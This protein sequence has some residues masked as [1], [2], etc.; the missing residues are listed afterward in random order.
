MTVAPYNPDDYPPTPLEAALL[1][2]DLGWRVI[3]IIPGRKHPKLERWQE[4]A[5]TDKDQIDRWWSSEFVGYGVGIA[6]G[7]ESGLWVLD[8][9]VAGDHKGEAS[10]QRLCFE[11]GVKSLR[12]LVLT[13]TSTTGS[14]G[15]H[16]FFAWPEGLV[17]TG[18]PNGLGPGLDLRAAGNQVLAPPTVHPSGTCYQWHPGRSPF[19]L[20]VAQ[21]PEALLERIVERRGSATTMALRGSGPLAQAHSDRPG[22]RYI[23]RTTWDELLTRYGW[24]PTT[25]APGPHGERRWTRPGKDRREGCSATTGY[26]EADVLKVF[27]SSVP[28]L[29]AGHTYNRFCFWAA[30][31]HGGDL[32]AAAR[33]LVDEER[34]TGPSANNETASLSDKVDGGNT[35]ITL[36]DDF[37]SARPALAHIRQAARARLIAP[38]ALLGAVLAR[39]A[40]HT[41]HRLV[42]PAI[43]G[44]T[45]SL[46]L[47][48]AIAGSSGDG[49]GS[50]LDESA[51]L[52]GSPQ[53]ARDFRVGEAP[54]GSGEG[55]VRAYF[56]MEKDPAD[57]RRMR[58]KLARESVLFRI[59]E[60]EVLRN[61]AARQGQTTFEHLRQMFSGEALG[62]SYVDDSR[63]SRLRAHGYRAAVLMAIQAGVSKFLF[64]DAAGG[65]PQRFLFLSAADPGAPAPKERPEHPGALSWQPPRFTDPAVRQKTF[66]LDGFLAAS[67]GVDGAIAEELQEARH[68]VLSGG[69]QDPLDAHKGLLRLKVAALLAIL[70]RRVDVDPEDWALAG[71][72]TD[73]SRKVRSSMHDLLTEEGRRKAAAGN[74]RA[75]ERAVVV[76]TAKRAA[77]AELD[78]VAAVIGRHMHRRHSEKGGDPC[79]RQCLRDAVGRDKAMLEAALGVAIEHG[80]VLAGD[81]GGYLAGESRPA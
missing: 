5:T 26:E 67:I 32:Q 2:A 43:V 8:V 70:G 60:G 68:R 31:E 24:Q 62:G 35:S 80:W 29:E 42:L 76:E 48:V 20:E 3:P 69:H 30:M 44:R 45:G 63:R 14:G 64:D 40:Q 15:K 52:L 81:D 55:M 4:L 27:S 54:A 7:P 10:M 72:V 18:S 25:A 61:L 13:V 33:A 71:L 59:D 46:N 38:D 16:L 58:L 12:E 1:Y 9:D 77:S 47:I 21:A 50:V 22:D 28:E 75:A 53:L 65:T 66:R 78:R 6:T 74:E 37:W 36:P 57:K 56:E 41:D 79:K 39:V 19:D 73:A 23:Q 51:A 11:L 17:I 34:R 49:K